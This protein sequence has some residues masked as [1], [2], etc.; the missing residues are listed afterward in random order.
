MT[1]QATQASKIERKKWNGDHYRAM[2]A[3]LRR[4]RDGTLPKHV[5]NLPPIYDE[6]VKTRTSLS[7]ADHIRINK[8]RLVIP[9]NVKMSELILTPQ[10]HPL[11]N[12]TTILSQKQ[13]EEEN[14]K[15]KTNEDVKSNVSTEL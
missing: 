15:V 3:P 2:I 9:E 6:L 12:G 7:F 1:H 5:P 4:N 8:P 10:S 11:W 13:W 14:A